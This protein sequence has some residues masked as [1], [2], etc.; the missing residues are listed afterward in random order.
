MKRP[1]IQNYPDS[2]RL[3]KHFRKDENFSTYLVA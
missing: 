3:Y 1:R 2:Y